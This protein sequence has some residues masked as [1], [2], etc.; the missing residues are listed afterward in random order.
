MNKFIHSIVCIPLVFS[1]TPSWGTETED[2]SDS[3]RENI[4]Y[5]LYD[6]CAGKQKTEYLNCRLHQKE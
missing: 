3:I 4:A 5:T 1:Q 2:P 6:P